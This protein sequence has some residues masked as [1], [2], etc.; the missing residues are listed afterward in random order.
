MSLV[1]C[2]KVCRLILFKFKKSLQADHFQGPVQGRTYQGVGVL[3]PHFSLG[4][5][6]KSPNEMVIG[7]Y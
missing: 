1:S 6:V 4:L 2:K 5:S 3:H 7:I